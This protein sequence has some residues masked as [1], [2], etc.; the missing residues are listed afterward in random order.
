MPNHVVFIILL[1]SLVN[2][3]KAQSQA[4]FGSYF[5]DQTMR[6]DYHHIADA[7]TE[8]IVLDRIYVQGPWAGSRKNLIDP[9]N[10]GGYRIEVR[11]PLNNQLLFSRGFDTYCAEYMT[12]AQAKQHQRS[13]HE[14]ALV[15][16]AKKSFIFR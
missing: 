2:T 11:D 10:Y 16:L 1:C 8:T 9:L 5:H 7:Q 13:F 12:T 6:I 4:A 14:S 3:P 15:P